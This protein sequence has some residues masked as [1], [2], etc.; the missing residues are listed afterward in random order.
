MTASLAADLALNVRGLETGY[1]R[2]QVVFGVDLQARGGAVTALIGANGAGKTTTLKALSGLLPVSGGSVEVWG[3]SARANDSADRIGQ[4]VVYLPQERAV[5]GELT[6]RDNLLLGA[7]RTSN[8]AV[9]QERYEMVLDLFPR[10]RER[11]AQRAG[12]MSGGEQRML[13]VSITLM[14]GARVLLLD[15]PSLGLA[16]RVV[17]DMMGAL[18]GL[19]AERELTILLVEQD[20]SGALAHADHVYV[21]RSGRVVWD[22]DRQA[23]IA[24]EDWSELF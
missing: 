6:V 3:N 18:A 21:M 10:L 4:G 19:V 12:T 2:T 24:I 13:S 20:I 22:G 23:A 1:G 15:E 16:P 8:R 9:R 11:L 17:Q 7:T 5:F 14:A